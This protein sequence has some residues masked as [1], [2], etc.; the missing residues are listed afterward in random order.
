MSEKD[1]TAKII[2]DSIRDGLD[3]DVDSMSREDIIDALDELDYINVRWALRDKYH[4]QDVEIVR[5]AMDKEID[6]QAAR[7]DKLEEENEILK[8]RI[9]TLHKRLL[10]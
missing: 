4:K 5:S 9:A 2:A 10:G 1:Y 3:H 7:A 6:K 8:K